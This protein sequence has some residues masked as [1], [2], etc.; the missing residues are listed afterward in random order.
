MKQKLTVF[1]LVF[2][3]LFSLVACTSLNG[4]SGNANQVTFSMFSAPKGLFNPVVYEDAYDANV[5]QYLFDGL[6][7]YDSSLRI[8]T[9]N[10]LAQKYEFSPDNKSLTIWMKKGPKW[11]DG[12]PI[13]VDDMIFTW[14]C[15]ADPSYK[16]VRFSNVAMIR[17]AQEKHDK[18]AKTISGITRLDDYTVKVEFATPEANVLANIWTQPIPKHVFE[19]VSVA[20][21]GNAPATREQIV[22]SGPF[23]V[24]EIKPNEYVTLERNS[25]YYRGAPKVEKIVLKVLAQDVAIAALQKGEIDLLTQ[26]S[27]REVKALRGNKNLV[28]KEY[29][30]FA[31]QYMGINNASPKLSD[32]RVRQALTYAINRKALV[33][34]L[35]EGKGYVLNQHEPK[36]SW[37]YNKNLENVYPYDVKKAK[38]LLA[39]AGYKDVNGD[40]FVEDPQGKPYT[41]KLDYPT[42]NPIREDSAPIIVEDLKKAGINVEL[43]QPREATSHYTHIQQG[44]AEL[45]LAGWSL[46]PDPDPKG[47]WQSTDAFN[48]LHYNNP[49]SDRLIRD[50]VSS[51][52]AFTQDGRKKIYDKWTSL[53]SFDAPQVFLYGQ[54]QADIYSKRIK[55]ITT[56]WRGIV[57]EDC[58]YWSISNKK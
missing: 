53:I 22:G 40:G 23:K 15:L 18:K 4:L 6:W 20:D 31:Y 14:E 48:Y 16:G 26:V 27:P 7:S 46:T 56:D 12:K 36:A 21:F 44:K 45:Y 37:A 28:I 30:D 34:G 50:G 42:G 17:G 57:T 43:A 10:G 9:K 32:R 5:I 38:A 41:L 2:V 54:K 19:K 55:G 58:I 3:L 13:T 24:K 25:E 33:E 29:D 51:A 11:H 47:I 1:S 39:E 8:S 49:E 35:L 52:A